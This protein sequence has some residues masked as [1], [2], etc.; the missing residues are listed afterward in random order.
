M[1]DYD[2][3]KKMLNNSRKGVVW[4][5]LLEDT[6]EYS[7]QD[8]AQN[9]ETQ[10]QLSSQ[11]IEDEKN[12]F[13]SAVTKLSEFN[14][15]KISYDNVTWGGFMPKYKIEWV[16]SIT[17]EGALISC[18][19]TKLNEETLKLI[20]SLYA[21]YEKWAEKWAGE[22]GVKGNDTDAAGQEGTPAPAPAAG[23]PATPPPTGI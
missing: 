23:A 16:F 3:M 19:L 5:R 1:N 8:Q 18:E 6:G 10:R 7:N 4:R 17:D 12:D 11:E 20:Q 14:D 9:K 13:A 2:D 22:I 15:F 21:Y